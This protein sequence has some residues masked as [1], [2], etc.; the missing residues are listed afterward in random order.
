MHF[1]KAEGA[2]VCLTKR[3]G[4]HLGIALKACLCRL[5]YEKHFTLEE[6]LF[7]TTTCYSLKPKISAATVC[8]NCVHP[9]S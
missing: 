3:L 5:V 9:N 1:A 8:L 4:I 6:T 2:A 7:Q